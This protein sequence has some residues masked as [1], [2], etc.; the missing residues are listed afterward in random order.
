MRA[1]Y[2]LLRGQVTEIQFYGEIV[3]TDGNKVVFASE[4]GLGSFPARSLLKPFQF[5]A[6]DLPIES[7]SGAKKELRYAACSGS[8]SATESQAA[9][10]NAWYEHSRVRSQISKVKFA[11]TFPMDER[12]RVSMKLRGESPDPMHHTCFSKHMAILESCAIN[13]WDEGS[14]HS[15]DH[16]YHHRLMKTLSELLGED[17]S[18]VPVV[19]DGC[20]LPSPVLRLSQLA[21]LYQRLASPKS[22]PRLVKIRDLML[23][24]PGWIGGPGR[25][26][27]RLM[28]S[29]AGKVIAKEGA[30]G[31]IAVAVLPSSQFPDGLGMVIKNAAGFYALPTATALTP[32]F[33]SLGLVPVTEVPRGQTIRFHY[34]T[35]TSGA[36]PFDAS[37]VLEEGIAVWPGD[38]EFHRKVSSD[39][40]GGSHLTLSAVETTVHVGAHADSPRHFVRG[41][42][43]ID[44][45]DVARYLGRCQVVAVKT[46]AGEKIVPADLKGKSLLAPRILFKTGSFPDP[47]HFNKD[48]CS[49][50]TEVIEWLAKREICLVGIDTPSVDPY[51]SKTLDAHHALVKWGMSHLEGLDLRE[52]TEG[53][54]QLLAIPLR[55]KDGDGSPVRAILFPE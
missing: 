48:F 54:Y 33:E 15:S 47:R 35:E 6:A 49:F 23:E 42:I 32:L 39:V 1:L 7:W 36:R 17:V 44:Q 53:F 20:T 31:L 19:E 21:H 45:V 50:S 37:P 9:Q 10:L 46:E 51:S 8:I 4:P 18:D 25:S 43:G 40:N 24:N 12:H 34:K 14:Y 11:P 22:D 55:L 26:D 5:F 41:G 16:P 27:T 13:G 52:V 30:D 29:N 2:S 38:V 28:E 3:A